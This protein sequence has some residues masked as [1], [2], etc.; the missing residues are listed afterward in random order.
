MLALEMGTGKTLC[1]IT[2][3]ILEQ[4]TLPDQPA[5]HTKHTEAQLEEHE[6][7][8]VGKRHPLE[9]EKEKLK[10]AR[11]YKGF[12]QLQTDSWLV[13]PDGSVRATYVFTQARLRC[14]P[15]AV[16]VRFMSS[17]R[18]CRSTHLHACMHGHGA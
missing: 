14:W 13:V 6:V 16:Y 9:P 12:K 18:N 3:H 1:A 2:P 17:T 7:V 11:M 15:L 5:M 4:H 8:Y 10:E